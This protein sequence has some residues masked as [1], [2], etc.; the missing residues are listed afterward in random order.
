MSRRSFF[1]LSILTLFAVSGAAA[2]LFVTGDEAGPSARGDLLFPQLADRTSDSARIRVSAVGRSIII[3]RNGEGWLLPENGGYPVRADLANALVASL[4]SLKANEP[5]TSNPDLYAHIGVEDAAAPEARSKLVSVETVQGDTLARALVGKAS[6]SIGSNP[7]GGT[8]VR[9]P[10]ETQSWLAE[11]TAQV[12]GS[13]SEWLESIVHVPGPEVRRITIIEQDTIVFEAV[14]SGP[15]G[16]NYA[17]VSV[18]SRYGP[19]T[20]VANDVAIKRVAQG[21]V[22]TRFE[23]VRAAESVEFGPQSR[24]V[25]F[26]LA[27]GMRLDVQIGNQSWVRYDA[28]A[29]GPGEA[30]VHAAQIANKTRGFA[31]RL[32]E[33]KLS[34]LSADISGLLKSGE[35]AAKSPESL[36]QRLLPAPAPF[37]LQ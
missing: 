33:N 16:T 15:Q 29:S 24:T 17:L 34:A 30:A 8:F 35:A 11:G 26:D 28:S 27:D 12:P 20:S 14:K 2:A 9:R 1:V 37:Q 6:V 23:D 4:A 36:M 21:I 22:S 31:Y 5:K 13:L 18:D 10:E 32:P 19:P 3:E 7:L 25:R